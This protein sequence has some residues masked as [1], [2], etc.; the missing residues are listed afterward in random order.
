LTA[1]TKRYGLISCSSE[2]EGSSSLWGWHHLRGQHRVP[3]SSLAT[4]NQVASYM[5]NPGL[6]IA[7]SPLGRKAKMAKREGGYR[8]QHDAMVLHALPF[9][10]PL[11]GQKR[12]A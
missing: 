2:P 10:N 12:V 8:H 6:I 5:H 4:S 11:S 9:E 3:A 7:P 1:R